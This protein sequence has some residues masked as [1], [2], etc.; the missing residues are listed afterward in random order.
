MDS[1]STSTPSKTSAMFS[2]LFAHKQ[3][4]PKEDTK[5]SLS[6]RSSATFD[7]T[8][9]ENNAQQTKTRTHKPNY[10]ARVASALAK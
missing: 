7:L 2:K 3:S 1:A 4:S 6:S 10:E 8:A 9:Q 5:T